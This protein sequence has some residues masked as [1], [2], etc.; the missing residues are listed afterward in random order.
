MVRDILLSSYHVAKGLFSNQGGVASL[1]QSHTKNLSAFH[2]GRGVDG[3][4]L[5]DEIAAIFL[6]FEERERIWIVGR[7]DDQIRHLALQKLSKRHID[8]ITHSDRIA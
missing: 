1:L 7:S 6:R 8:T 3:V 5:Q 4:D 2:L